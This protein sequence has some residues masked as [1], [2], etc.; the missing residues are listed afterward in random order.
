MQITVDDDYV[1]MLAYVRMLGR[2]L[3][4]V[5][6]GDLRARAYHRQLSLEVQNSLPATMERAGATFAEG[7]DRQTFIHDT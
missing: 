1:S 2:R 7:E 5:L 3:A 4:P 6:D